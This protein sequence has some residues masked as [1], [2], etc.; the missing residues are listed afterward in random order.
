MPPAQPF[1]VSTK[2]KLAALFAPASSHAEQ[3]R[4]LCV[5]LRASL[6]LSCPQMATVLG[7]HPGSVRPLQARLVR[8]GIGVLEQPGRGGRHRAHLSRAEE[9]ALLADFCFAAGQ[10]G[11]V[12]SG[13][14]RAADEKQ[15]GH[16]VAKSPLYRLLARPGW[17]KL[18]PR[19]YH[20]EAS[21]QAQ[22]AFKKAPARGERRSRPTSDSGA[23]APADVRGRG[24]LWPPQ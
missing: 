5:W 9:E 16:P 17:R 15:V 7:W 23:F 21:V 2:R 18:A 11:V 19:P 6:G 13:R 4:I 8:A 12:E 1:S 3:E 20:P 24:A 10:G 22:Q 14:L